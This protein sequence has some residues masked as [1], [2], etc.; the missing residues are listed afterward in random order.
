MDPRLCTLAG[1]GV[2]R[3]WRSGLL[4]DAGE[5]ARRLDAAV[6]VQTSGVRVLR[7]SPPAMTLREAAADLIDAFTE[8]SHAVQH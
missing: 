2:G 8:D 3:R 7:A 5:Y 6:L 1:V 4:S